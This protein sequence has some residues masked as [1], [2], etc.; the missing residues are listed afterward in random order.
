MKSVKLQTVKFKF[1]VRV[2]IIKAIVTIQVHF[3]SKVV[4]TRNI[5]CSGNC[6]KII[7]P[8]SRDRKP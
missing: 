2:K 6:G 5:L 4:L 1:R 7:N 8:H 3:S